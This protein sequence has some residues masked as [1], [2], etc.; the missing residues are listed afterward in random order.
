MIELSKKSRSQIRTIEV[1]NSLR[2]L[3]AWVSNPIIYTFHQLAQILPTEENFLLCFRQFVGSSTEFMAV[4]DDATFSFY[5]STVIYDIYIYLYNIWAPYKYF[6]YT[7]SLQCIAKYFISD[8]L[9]IRKWLS[10][11]CIMSSWRENG[12]KEK[13]KLFNHP[14]W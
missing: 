1:F 13:G 4:S 8:G 12:I 3:V 10:Q 2:S 6:P 11:W 7:H 14:V 9:I 5:R